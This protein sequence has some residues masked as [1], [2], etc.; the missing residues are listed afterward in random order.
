MDLAVPRFD[1][2]IFIVLG[3]FILILDV[4][5]DTFSFAFNLYA[6]VDTKTANRNI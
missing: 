1:L 6:D 5:K 4:V 2:I 3:I